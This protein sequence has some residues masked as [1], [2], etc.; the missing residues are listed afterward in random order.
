MRDA[1]LGLH[2]RDDFT[3][4][5]AIHASYRAYGDR[6]NLGANGTCFRELEN[7]LSRRL[8]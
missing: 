6:C 7:G 2:W 1:A 5:G 4:Y 3:A 8:R